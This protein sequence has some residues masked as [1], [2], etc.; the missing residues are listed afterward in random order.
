MGPL[1]S[2]TVRA[3]T[4]GEAVGRGP[5]YPLPSRRTRTLLL[6][7]LS[8]IAS[9]I[10]RCGSA[11]ALVTSLLTNNSDPFFHYAF[12]SYLFPQLKGCMVLIWW[13]WGHCRTRFGMS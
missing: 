5:F 10:D 8:R 6:I 1:L 11:K 4:Y 13:L 12:N 9:F 7:E 3:W 2:L